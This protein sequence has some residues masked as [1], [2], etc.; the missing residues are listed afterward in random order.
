MEEQ[1]LSV[2]GVVSFTF[3]MPQHRC[4]VRMRTDLK[5]EVREATMSTVVKNSIPYYS[6]NFLPGEKNRQSVQVAKIKPLNF[7]ND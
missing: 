3:N 2:K 6:G 1:L 7:S 4:V 5:A